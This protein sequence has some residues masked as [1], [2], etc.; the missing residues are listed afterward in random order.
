MS[1]VYIAYHILEKWPASFWGIVVG[2]FFSLGGVILGN[3]ASDRRF[4]AQQTQDR[5]LKREEREHSLRKE[6]YLDAAEAVSFQTNTLAKVINPLLD[7]EAVSYEYFSRTPKVAKAL[8][9]AGDEIA[10]ALLDIGSTLSLVYLRLSA[11]RASMNTEI[12]E[13]KTLGTMIE[14]SS[15]ERSRSLELMKQINIDGVT[16]DRRWSVINNNFQ[17]EQN[18]ISDWNT[19]LH[20]TRQ[21]LISK[22]VE[23]LDLLQNEIGTINA[24]MIFALAAVK[25]EL[26]FPFNV[27][28][29]LL[30]SEEGLRN[31]KHELLRMIQQAQTDSL[32]PDLESNPA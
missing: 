32:P 24:K 14:S 28:A 8:V 11:K 29:F 15:K 19:T 22:Q 12:T 26:N 10:K 17:F 2:S 23:A 30:L 18:R 20:L 16:D 31:Q 27:D 13:I 7:M 21:N 5:I 3:R 9:V 25:R 6:L 1:Y 4:R